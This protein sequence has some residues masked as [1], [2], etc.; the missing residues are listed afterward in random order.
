MSSF[1]AHSLFPDGNE[2]LYGLRITIF[3]QSEPLI[4]GKPARVISDQLTCAGWFESLACVNPEQ[5][6]L[7]P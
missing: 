2:H 7:L 3:T 5:P 1:I 4:A 6:W